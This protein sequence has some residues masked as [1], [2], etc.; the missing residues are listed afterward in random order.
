MVLVNHQIFKYD[1][2]FEHS[3]FNRSQFECFIRVFLYTL[4]LISIRQICLSKVCI[5][6]RYARFAA[7]HMV[8]FVVDNMYTYIGKCL[9]VVG[10]S[11]SSGVYG[12]V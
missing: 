9:K 4:T 10:T 3:F 12:F 6:A 2:P 7:G 11:K 5:P 1:T 8:A